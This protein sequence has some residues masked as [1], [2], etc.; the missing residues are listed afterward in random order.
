MD[1]KINFLVRKM[2]N[3]QYVEANIIGKKVEIGGKWYS[4]IQLKIFSIIFN[5]YPS[6]PSDF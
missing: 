5:D 6:D 2:K 3:T 1:G 4:A